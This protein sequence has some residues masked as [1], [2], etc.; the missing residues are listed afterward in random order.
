MM[1]LEGKL[2][3][4]LTGQFPTTLSK[5]NKYVSILYDYDGNA[6][7]AEPMKSSAYYEDVRAYTVVYKQLTHAGLQTKFQMMDNTAY[8]TVKELFCKENIQ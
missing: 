4:N 3:T 7:L 5:G 6:I 1:E 8:A 2:F